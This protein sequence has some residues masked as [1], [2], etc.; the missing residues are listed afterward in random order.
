[1]EGKNIVLVMG[2]RI[3]GMEDAEGN[4]YHFVPK[5]FKR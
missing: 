2:C 5:V 3:V 1:M 4:V